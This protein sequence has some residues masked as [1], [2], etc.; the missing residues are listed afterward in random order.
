MGFSRKMPENIEALQ[1]VGKK[2]YKADEGAVLFSMGIHAFERLGAE[3]NA[4][5]RR[6][7]STLYNVEKINEYMENFLVEE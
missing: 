6:G 5:Y 4:K 7:K 1:I 2:F 3:A